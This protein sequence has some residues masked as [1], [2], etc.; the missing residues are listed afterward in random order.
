MTPEW[1][2]AEYELMNYRYLFTN[3]I[4]AYEYILPKMKCLSNVPK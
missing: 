1:D 4:I 3:E 2:E